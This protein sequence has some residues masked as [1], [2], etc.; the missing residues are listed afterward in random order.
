MRSEAGVYRIAC[1]ENGKSYIGRTVNVRKRWAS[2]RWELAR[3]THRNGRLQAD[4]TAF[5]ASAFR[6]DVLQVVGGLSGAALDAA[7]AEA[8]AAH[9]ARIPLSDAYNLMEAGT[10]GL[11]ASAETRAK[12][13]AER[14]ARWADPAY[15]ER[16]RAAHRAK[17][18][19]PEWSANRTAAIRASRGTAQSRARTSEATKANWAPGGTLR[20][21]Q[22]DKQRSHWTD[23]DYRARQSASRRAS[24]ADPEVKARRSAALKAA[25]ARRKALA[26]AKLT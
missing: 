5:G 17:H 14:K 15:R 4:W 8:E 9:L 16:L 19:D 6:F 26:A 21:T 11:T 10:P 23:P 25:H 24:H 3:G 12:W 13:S 1:I 22:G 7:L 18:A 2:H 20:K